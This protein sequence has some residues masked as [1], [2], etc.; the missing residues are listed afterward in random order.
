MREKKKVKHKE[1]E[2][3]AKTPIEIPHVQNYAGRIHGK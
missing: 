2:N 3:L 1:H